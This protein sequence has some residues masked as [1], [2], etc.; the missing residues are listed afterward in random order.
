LAPVPETLT[1]DLPSPYQKYHSDHQSNETK[2]L[3]GIEV[4]VY[5]ASI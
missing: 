3:L 4:P 5:A 1:T 2:L